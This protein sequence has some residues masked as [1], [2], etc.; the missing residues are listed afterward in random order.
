MIVDDAI[1]AGCKQLLPPPVDHSWGSF[2]D[3]A[4]DGIDLVD[5]AAVGVVGDAS[6]EYRIPRRRT[7]ACETSAK[8]IGES[9]KEIFLKNCAENKK[10]TKM[11]YDLH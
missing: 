5:D 8:E 10:I 1:D 11:F 7:M 3:C 9:A 4:T 6:Q 2:D